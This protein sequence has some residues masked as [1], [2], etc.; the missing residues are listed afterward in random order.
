[1][2][3]ECN[4]TRRNSDG[5]VA[6]LKGKLSSTVSFSFVRV[7]GFPSLVAPYPNVAGSGAKDDRFQC[8]R[9]ESL[10]L[11]SILLHLAVTPTLSRTLDGANPWLED[12]T[13]HQAN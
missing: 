2:I 13:T 4:A 6:F 10:Y 8:T 7:L 1:M 3:L 5:K 11:D 12:R 9:P